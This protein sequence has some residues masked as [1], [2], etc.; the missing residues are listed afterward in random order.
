MNRTDEPKPLPPN[1]DCPTCQGNGT[2]RQ[3][4]DVQVC[5]CAERA[6]QRRE[7]RVKAVFADLPEDSLF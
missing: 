1:P 4:D 6:Q 7:Q 3:V 2:F 5:P